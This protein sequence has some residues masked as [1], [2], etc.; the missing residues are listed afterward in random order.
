MTNQTRIPKFLKKWVLAPKRSNDIVEQIL[1]NRGVKKS[2]WRKFL[3]PK[4]DDLSDPFKIKDMRLAIER[5]VKAIKNDEMIGV[6]GDYDADGIPAAALLY[7]ALTLCGA[8]SAVYIPARERGYGLSTEGIDYLGSLGAKVIVAVDLGMTAKNEVAQAAKKGIDVIVVDHHTVQ[9]GK[10]PDQAAALVNPKQATDHS[11][12]K[13]YAACGL[14]YKL[15]MALAQKTGKISQTKL[16]WLLDL[17]AISTVGD[18]VP[19]QGENRIITK[20]GLIVLQKTRRI[21]LQ[22]LYQKAGVDPSAIAAST[23]SFTIAPRL[24][25]PGRME[26]PGL[27]LSHVSPAFTLLITQD[28]LEADRLASEVD[29]INRERQAV[30]DKVIAQAREQ[31]EKD[32]L[33]ERKLIMVVGEQWP[34][35]VVGLVAGRLMDEYTRPT[36]VLRKEEGIVKGSARSIEA[37]NIMEAF[38]K[39]KHHLLKHGGHPRAA[40]LSMEYKHLEMVY[41]KLLTLAQAKLTDED[42]IPKIKVDAK[43]RLSDLSSRLYSRIKALEPHGVGNPKPVL[44]VEDVLVQEAR[45]VGNGDKHLKLWL[46]QNGAMIGGIGFDLGQ[47]NSSFKAGDSVDLVGYLDQDH[48]NGR[49]RLNIKVLD[50]KKRT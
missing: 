24:N 21:G 44:L 46:K 13:D 36:I 16:K 19:L 40:G 14:A 25:S 23:L 12:F 47:L 43:L 6:F 8:K 48:W 17:P 37:F 2:D 30:L 41:D 15:V 42:L 50:L 5:V 10:L 35:G 22:K 4:F 3:D 34:A 1:L 49:A 20:F 38:D 32:K 27:P 11:L 26:Q 31:I 39:V 7:E 45:R 28:E 29:K 9:Q 18:M 33:H